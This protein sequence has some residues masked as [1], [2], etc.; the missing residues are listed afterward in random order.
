MLTDG[1]K[2]GLKIVEVDNGNL[3]FL[4]NESKALDISQLWKEGENV[5][6]LSKNG[7]NA[8][9]L[10][11]ARRFEGGMLYTCGLNSVGDRA[12]HELHGG[13]HNTPAEIFR[14]DCNEE[15]IAVSARISDSALFGKNLV[16]TR[17][18]ETLVGS[19]TL[20]VTDTLEN[21]GTREEEYCIL[22]HV[23]LGYPFLDQGVTIEADEEEAIPRTAWAK[24]RTGDRLVFGGA[25]DGEEERCY[26]IRHKTPF[27]R[28]VNREKGRA[29]ELAYSKETLPCFVQWNSA[30]SGDYALGL[31]PSTTCLDGA[32]AYRRIAPKERIVFKL[33]L[34]VKNLTVR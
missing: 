7:L 19:D 23:N 34:A 3:R 29:F 25:A 22:Y 5:S 13:F 31:E 24:E 2:A 32:F 26:F 20:T 17:T 30:A 18:V 10:P 21:M 12:G 4:L 27:V 33:S 6:F 8:R 16:L 1:A 9:E 14:I 15:K 28:V 11:F